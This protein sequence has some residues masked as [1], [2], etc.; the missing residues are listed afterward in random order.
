MSN[1]RLKYFHM[2]RLSVILML[3]FSTSVLFAQNSL[4]LEECVHIAI[5]NN[6]TLQ[7]SEINISKSQ[8][9]YEQSKLA[10]LPS[11][12]GNTSHSL[13]FGRSLDFT[14]YDFNTQ[15]TN[16]NSLGVSAGVTLFNGGR[17]RNNVEL[18]KLYVESGQTNLK[19][20]KENIAIEVAARYLEVLLSKERKS[21][22]ENTYKL[23]EKDLER[24]TKLIDNGGKP[25]KY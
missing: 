3:L 18:Q 16:S 20:A 11:V 4:T 10:K 15:T 25:T 5:E 8:S 7:Q 9:N 14:T 2:K 22:S 21:V 12:N 19:T 24:T 23:R 13:N 17:I 6:L 1:R